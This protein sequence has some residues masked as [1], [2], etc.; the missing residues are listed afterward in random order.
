MVMFALSQITVNSKD[1]DKTED[2]AIYIKSNGVH[3]DIVFPIRSPYKDW[4]T[5]ADPARTISRD[6]TFQYAAFGWGDRDFYLNT[7]KWSDLKTKTAFKAA[8][9]M[10]TGLMHVTFHHKPN[11]HDRCV[12]VMVSKAEYLRMVAFVESSFIIANGKT[13]L[14]EG[15][16]YGD[17]DLFF[18]AKGK[19]NLFY[20]CNAWANNCLK[21]G[22]QKAALW[23]LTDTGILGHYR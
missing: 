23:S 1:E 6:T 4:V 13:V 14:I 17:H 15:A 10:G 7:P 16:S 12:K 22:G 18:E 19:Y 8:F 3:T 9:W 20:T 5:L 21:S 11:E 2:V